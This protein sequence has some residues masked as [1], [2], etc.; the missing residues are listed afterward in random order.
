MGFTNLEL[1]DKVSAGKKH[2]R[3]TTIE[4]YLNPED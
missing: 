1:K 2:L 3:V 4:M